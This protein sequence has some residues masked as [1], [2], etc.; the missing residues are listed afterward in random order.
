MAEPSKKSEDIEAELKKAFGFDRRA[1]IKE[2]F[3][4]P[5]PLG[6]GG[7]ADKF[8][9]AASAR[10]YTISGLCQECQDKFFV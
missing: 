4:I 7:R 6:C 2:N 1:S 5:K 8:K 3:C 9:D 10:E